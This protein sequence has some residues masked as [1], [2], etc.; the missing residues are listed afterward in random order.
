MRHMT[1]V[2]YCGD[3]NQTGSDLFFVRGSFAIHSC[4]WPT[5]R[6]V[7]GQ[8]RAR[9]WHVFRSDYAFAII[10][11]ELQLIEHWHA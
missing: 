7:D 10:D 4:G 8:W 2:I 6:K 1:V 5:I 11:G 3:A 9:L